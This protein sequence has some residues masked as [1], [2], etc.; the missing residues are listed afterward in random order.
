MQ[1]RRNIYKILESGGSEIAAYRKG[2]EVMKARSNANQNDPTGWIFQANMHGTS[3]RNPTFNQFW[4]QCQHGS[5][6]FLSWHRMYI[7]FFER[8]VRAASGDS[9]FS[10]PYWNYS[11][12]NQSVL[13]EPFRI[14]ADSSNTLY[15]SQRRNQINQGQPLPAN[16][17]EYRTALSYV[18]FF[19]DIGSL[20]PSFG[21]GVVP[22]PMQFANPNVRGQ[23]ENQPHNVIHTVIGGAGWMSD[24]LLAARDPIF[25]LH[26]SN[27]DRL[28]E[29]WLNQ[30]QGRSNPVNNSTWINTK[31]VFFN[32]NGQKQEMSG[33][34]I[35]DTASQ[36]NYIYD[37]KPM[38]PPPPPPT[39]SFVA[40][41]STQP[42]FLGSTPEGKVIQ[43]TTNAAEFSISPVA[44]R[45]AFTALPVENQRVMLVFEGI[46]YEKPP[47]VN[48]E[49]YLNLPDDNSAPKQ[50]NYV[51]T[52]GL[53]AM[54]PHNHSHAEEHSGHDEHMA[55]EHG[56]HD[57]GEKHPK[58]TVVLEATKVVEALQ[59]QGKWSGQFR[60]SLVTTYQDKPLSEVRFQ[61]ISVYTF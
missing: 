49:V 41:R 9:N 43:L 42:E 6:F 34:D 7:Y 31:F 60:I 27:I 54:E 50:E 29:Q 16:S 38:T 36:L 18:N 57:T 58:P 51:G 35:L 52:I 22:G 56:N 46:E 40:P 32:E 37:D 28:W 17:V 20:A 1:T 45:A 15:V 33:K 30:G 44:Q 59:K 14:P 5:F 53:F 13:P 26:H 25:W 48:Y 12:R 61:K 23:L 8:I 24:P 47:G 39:V 55:H 10:L 4:N 2:V 19:S 21:G 3:L 11:E